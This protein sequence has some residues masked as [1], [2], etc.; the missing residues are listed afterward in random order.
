MKTLFKIIQPLYSVWSYLVFFLFV[1]V[2]LFITPL[3]IIAA[4]KNFIRP[5]MRY[6]RFWSD[7]WFALS[8]M[9]QDFTGYEFIDPNRSYVI[10]GT[11]AST[12]DLFA[13][14]SSIKMAYK[15]LAKVETGK[16]PVVGYLFRV[17]CLF[18]D[19][20]SPESRKAS[21]DTMI[22][23][24]KRGTSIMIMPEGTRNRTD[25]PLQPFHDGAFRIAIE[26]QTPLLPFVI[27]NVR[28]LMP[29]NTWLITPGTVG[30]RFLKPIETSGMTEKDIPALK[31]KVYKLQ[32]EVILREDAFFEASRS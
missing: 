10:T 4:G 23:E 3:I 24:L 13:C 15:T 7:V 5:L 22:K 17:A 9:K 26:T 25:K 6:Y 32:E 30:V 14:G 19:R 2:S 20:S 21:I 11:H 16:I 29:T 8:F 12:L 18:V 1:A 31:E 28:K 27:L